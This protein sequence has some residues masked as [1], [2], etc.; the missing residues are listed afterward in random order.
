MTRLAFATLAFGLAVAAA[1]QETSTLPENDQTSPV[2]FEQAD[3]NRDGRVNRDESAVIEGFD[4]TGADA[5]DDRM[6]S[7]LEFAAAMAQGDG[8]LTF[9]RADKN[10]DGKIDRKEAEEISG[11]N[12][13]R[14]GQCRRLLDRGAAA[15]QSRL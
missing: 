4:F 10:R 8:L 9:A 1:A 5:N 13:R 14:V 6:L 7:R 2:T 15:A 11:L 3:K 12:C